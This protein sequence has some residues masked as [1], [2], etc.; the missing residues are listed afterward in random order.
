M[1]HFFA[2]ASSGTEDLLASELRGLGARSVQP[3]RGVVRFDGD[4]ELALRGCLWLRTAMRVLQPIASFPAIDGDALYA[5]VRAIDWT[6]HLD[7]S[8][9]FAVDATGT[10][11]ELR[12]THFTALKVK[13]A[14]VDAL[15]D[16]TGRRPNVDA[17]DP[18]LR[19]VVHL[20]RGRCEVSLDL[21]GEPLFKRGWRYDPA[22]A[23]MKE[24][25]AASMLLAIGYNGKA[26]LLD[27]LCGA[28]TIAIEAAT[29]AMRR[30]PGIG[31]SFAVERWP[32]FDA[33]LR[34]KLAK[35]RDE[36]RAGELRDHP[37]ILASDRDPEAVAATQANVSRAQVKV[38]VRERDAREAEPFEHPGWIVCNP[39]Y[40]ERLEGGGRKQLKTFF[41]QL[42]QR[43]RTFGGHQIAVLSGGPE[44]ESAFGLRPH[45]RRRMMNGP[46]ECTLLQYDVPTTFSEG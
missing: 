28:G 32:S 33:S 11:D 36:A 27:P 39:P 7:P 15:R 10:T 35:L 45:A 19:V 12:H 29:I 41:W 20:G 31:R 18:D 34:S 8:R 43:W 44:F 23:S 2:T 9:T 16:K 6:A 40:G 4:I 21:S 25:L 26:P 24:T 22:K 37:E 30:A 5:G 13:D 17:R 1:S 3:G 42:G 46:I 14:I 38:G